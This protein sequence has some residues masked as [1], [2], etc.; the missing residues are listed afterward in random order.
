MPRA[1]LFALLL[2]LALGC[3]C[4]PTPPPSGEAVPAYRIRFVPRFEMVEEPMR[5]GG[6]VV[7]T[8][9]CRR[10]VGYEPQEVQI[11]WRCE[12]PAEGDLPAV[13]RD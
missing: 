12:P 13:N 10:F 1:P 2:L 8:Q 6:E 11:G 5:R 3:A 4:S 9:W 7:G